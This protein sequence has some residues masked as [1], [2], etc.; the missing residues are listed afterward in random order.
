MAHVALA[1]DAALRIELRN[2]VGTVPDAVLASDARFRGVEN[3]SGNRIFLVSVDGAAT[4][5]I[6]GETVVTS[7]R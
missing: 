4:K 6:G 7:H 5:A 2:R 3:N 1:D